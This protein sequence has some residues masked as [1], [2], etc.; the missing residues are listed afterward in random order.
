[1]FIMII[2]SINFIFS[3]TT[4]CVIASFFLTYL[5]T[6]GILFSTAVRAVVVAKFVI[7]G[8]LFL[9][10]FILPLLLNSFILPLKAVVILVD[11]VYCITNLLIFDIPLLYYY[12]NLRLSITF[13]LSSGD[14]YLS[15]G[16]SSSF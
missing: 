6:L 11:L 2:I 13:C 16:I 1:M 14:I 10:S 15:L 9:T 5:L 7:L 4:F 8:I 3:F 12:I